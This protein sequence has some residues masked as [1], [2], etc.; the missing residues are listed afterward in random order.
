MLTITDS[1][2]Q[3]VK[4]FASQN[5]TYKGKHFRIYLQGGGCSGFSYGFAFDEKREGDTIVQ[6]G[7]LE[8]LV[9][10]QSAPYLKD[11]KIDYV[12]DLYG[13]GFVI[14]NPNERGRCGCG[15]SVNF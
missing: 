6:A 2:I 4:H 15:N 14:H 5:E 3:K 9:D 1:A 8:V 10:P 11:C 7:D 13:A 12:E